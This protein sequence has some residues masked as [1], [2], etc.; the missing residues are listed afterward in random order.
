[1]AA[2]Q[3]YVSGPLNNGQRPSSH[4]FHKMSGYNLDEFRWD[5]T[6]RLRATCE[7]FVNPAG[8]VEVRWRR[9]GDHSMYQ[10]P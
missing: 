4:I 7:M 8:E 10:N 3:R 1:M 9:I 6:G 2:V 5:T